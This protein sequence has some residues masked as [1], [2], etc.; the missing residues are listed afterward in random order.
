MDH[1][2]IN[3]LTTLVDHQKFLVKLL[4]K[5]D[6]FIRKALLNKNIPFLNQRLSYYLTEL[7]LPHTVEFTHEMTAEIS[8]F[9]RLMDFGNLSNG[10]RSRVNIALSFA[11]RDVLQN[12][13]QHI[14]VC[15]LDEVLDVGLDT[16]GVQAAAR[17]LKHKARDEQLSMYIISHRDEIDSAFDHRM[18][19][20]MSKGFSYI[21]FED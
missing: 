20:Q 15:M 1:E 21:K 11:F 3:E 16:V 6:S 5:K 14:N 8:Q 12:M 18:T 17:M 10:Q 2:K 19:I 7:G 9:G 4:T 13:H